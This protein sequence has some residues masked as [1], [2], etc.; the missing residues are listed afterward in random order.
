M[1]KPSFA[2]RGAIGWSE[3][4]P[5]R[6]GWRSKSARPQAFAR[7]R[8][9]GQHLRGDLYRPLHPSPWRCPVL[10]GDRRPNVE[11]H[12]VNG[13]EQSRGEVVALRLKHYPRGWQVQ[14]NNADSL[15]GDFRLEPLPVG[16]GET[17]QA[18]NLFDQ[19]HVATLTVRQEAK[20]FWPAQRGSALVFDIVG[21]DDHPFIC[22]ERL[23]IGACALCVL[24]F[25]RR[26]EIAPNKHYA[27]H[28]F[29]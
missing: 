23:K 17:R 10:A 29:A 6:F 21:G 2:W 27:P 3:S 18:V 13:V 19:E 24:F 12:R 22:G 20:Q 25:G 8:R 9:C 4:T 14:R 26:P 7:W 15:A 16:G 5:T 28:R 11:H 1:R